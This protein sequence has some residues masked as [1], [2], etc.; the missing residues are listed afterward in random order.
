MVLLAIDKGFTT[1]G[2]SGHSYLTI[3][4]EAA[5]SKEGTSRYIKDVLEMKEKYKDKINIFLGLEHD[6]QSDLPDKNDPYYH[7]IG[8]VHVVPVNDKYMGVDSC[9]E[10][11]DRIVEHYGSFIEYAKVYY[12]KV[13]KLSEIDQID[14]IGHVDL[15]M[16]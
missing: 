14:I 8:S 11:T 7:L 16:N 6:F 12:D 15:L 13:K 3:D 5:M 10:I 2:F 4:D 9:S 1:L